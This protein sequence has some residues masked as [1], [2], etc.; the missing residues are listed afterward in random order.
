MNISVMI[1][2]RYEELIGWWV[3]VCKQPVHIPRLAFCCVLAT[4]TRL[5]LVAMQDISW[6]ATFIV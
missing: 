4:A 5:E 1:S 6:L 2:I 3:C